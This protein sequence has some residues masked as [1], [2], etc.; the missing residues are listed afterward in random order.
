VRIVI[1]GTNLYAFYVPFN[2]LIVVAHLIINASKTVVGVFIMT[3]YLNRLLIALNSA[4][5]LSEVIISISQAVV[6]S[7]IVRLEFDQFF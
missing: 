6:D 3:P 5:K 4:F 1:V 7:C 2:R